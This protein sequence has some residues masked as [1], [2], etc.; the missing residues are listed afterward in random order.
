MTDV[1]NQ[2]YLAMSAVHVSALNYEH[3]L[4]IT[5]SLN[6]LCEPDYQHEIHVTVTLS[7]LPYM[8]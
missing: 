8:I 3:L 1:L 4:D 2:L 5:E 7:I 6:A